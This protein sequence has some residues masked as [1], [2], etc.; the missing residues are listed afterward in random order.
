MEIIK[1]NAYKLNESLDDKV[2]DKLSNTYN[3]LKRGVI[4]VIEQNLPENEKENIDS[5]KKVLKDIRE[6]EIDNLKLEGFIENSDIF[7]FYLKYQ[8]DIDE[9]LNDENYFDIIPKANVIFSLYD[10]II[11]GTKKAINYIVEIIEKE[12]EK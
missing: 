3:S 10:I 5:L 11:D 2:K 9:L 12:I 8:N 6:K 1:F 4:L 7:N